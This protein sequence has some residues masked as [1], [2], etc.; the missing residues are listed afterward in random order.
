MIRINLL[1]FRAARKQ[2]NVK[3][4]VLVFISVFAVSLIGLL[5]VHI[6]LGSMV[7]GREAEKADAEAALSKVQKQA[8]DVT[9]MKA[10]LETVQKRLVVINTLLAD[11][12]YP[13][14][15]LDNMTQWTVADRM[16][17]TDLSSDKEKLGISGVAVDDDTV[18]VFHKRLEDSNQFAMVSLDHMEQA[19]K[20]PSGTFQQFTI[21][22]YKPVSDQGSKST[23]EGGAKSGES[24]SGGA[25]SGGAKPG[26]AKPGDAAS[27][28]AKGGGK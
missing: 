9:D 7:R 21:T 22:C 27:N 3:R 4:Q 16:W 14:K 10:H 12:A 8:K 19:A 18:S 1:P 13:V 15:L 17:L 5:A 11:R 24:K 28:Q 23:K 6:E 20:Y 2:E 26:D 25:K